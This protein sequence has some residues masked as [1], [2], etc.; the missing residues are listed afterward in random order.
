MALLILAGC[1]GDNKLR[2]G[3]IYDKGFTEAY[4]QTSL[5]P[6]SPYNGK[7]VS[8]I[9]VPHTIYH[10]DSWYVDIKAFNE[11]EQK[12]VTARYWVDESVYNSVN[13]GEQFQYDENICLDEA[14]YTKERAD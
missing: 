10:P 3:E 4:T 13:I 9:L 6:I 2:E 8:T 14:P 12:W 7:T 5:L 1:A 11:E